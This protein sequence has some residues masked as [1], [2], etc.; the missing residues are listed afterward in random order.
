MSR[1][2]T[3]GNQALSHQETSTI[4][5]LDSFVIELDN[6]RENGWAADEEEQEAGVRCVAVPVGAGDRVLAAVSLS[7]PAER[8]GGGRDPELVR[9]MRRVSRSFAPA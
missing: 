8:F 3:S 6:V 7:G 9:T 2:S 1:R 5:E 4:T